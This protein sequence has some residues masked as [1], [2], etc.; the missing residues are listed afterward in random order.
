ML[1]GEEELEIPAEDLANLPAFVEFDGDEDGETL[2]VVV[3]TR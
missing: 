2:I 3:R 1:W